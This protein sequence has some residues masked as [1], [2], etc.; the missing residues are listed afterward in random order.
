[1]VLALR[2]CS[3]YDD[4]Q[5]CNNNY[6]SYVDGLC[7]FD[8]DKGKN[9]LVGTSDDVPR[10]GTFQDLLRQQPEL[11]NS[12][13]TSP[14]ECPSR[15]TLDLNVTYSST[16]A[17]GEEKVFKIYVD[18][19]DSDIL[20]QIQT[21]PNWNLDFKSLNVWEG[22]MNMYW[23]ADHGLTDDSW[24][25][26]SPVSSPKPNDLTWADFTSS[27]YKPVIAAGTLNTTELLRRWQKYSGLDASPS[28][29]GV[30]SLGVSS[31]I[32][33]AQDPR[34]FAGYYVF[35]LTNNNPSEIEFSV[36]VSA[37][38]HTNARPPPSG[39]KFDLATLG[40]IMIGVILAVTV[41]VFVIRKIRRMMEERDMARLA[42]ELRMLDEEEEEEERNR[43]MNGGVRTRRN[44]EGVEKKPMYKIV[45]GVQA[46]VTEQGL[47]HRSRT[48][49]YQGEPATTFSKEPVA[50]VSEDK[51]RSRVRS[52]YIRDLGTLANN[53][54]DRQDRLSKTMSV[55]EQ[56]IISSDLVMP[57][58]A[59]SPDI[60]SFSPSRRDS[61]KLDR[62]HSQ[63][64]R[65]QSDTEQDGDLRLSSGSNF[66]T[67][68]NLHRGW[69]LRSLGRSA[70]LKRIR[71]TKVRAEEREG[72]TQIEGSDQESE[73]PRPLDSDH[74]D[75]LDLATLPP[76]SQIRLQQ[77]PPV[78]LKRRNPIRIQPISIEPVPF[79]GALVPQTVRHLKKYH[80]NLAK[81]AR[82][83][84][85]R[86][87]ALEQQYQSSSPT[88]VNSTQSL[89][90][91][92]G[93]SRTFSKRSFT[94]GRS[95]SRRAARLSPSQG[96][97][98]QVQRT[99][100]LMTSRTFGGRSKAGTPTRQNSGEQRARDQT[101]EWLQDEATGIELA[102]MDKRGEHGQ[103]KIFEPSEE[104][105]NMPRKPMRM[106]GR[107][108]YDPGPLLAV[109]VL[110][111]FPGD[112]EARK[113]MQGGEMDG[114][115]G[116][117]P[118]GT[119]E[120]HHQD[121]LY[122]SNNHGYNNNDND[123]EDKDVSEQ[124]LPPMAIGTVFAP[125]PVRWWAYKAQ[126]LEDR[127]HFE[128]KLQKLEKQKKT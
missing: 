113:V 96:S 18:A 26:S 47:R 43:R 31:L 50:T 71:E 42:L 65:K 49:R 59:S 52:D 41:L 64:E 33:S 6:C 120:Q 109:N 124:R 56:D 108:E 72:L 14:N 57:Q 91:G 116:T 7:L 106:R 77:Q 46:L 45:V 76:S 54:R 61:K 84:Q 63:Q 53:I 103:G 13:L 90:A 78:Q 100:S 36:T 9:A 83:R 3:Q 22:F 111:V 58:T 34:R 118:F 48:I 60:G 21:V 107:R 80:R 92:P 97:L 81:N 38:N 126:H 51:R 86:Q 102:T 101:Q 123:D 98:R 10:D 75:M 1:M 79:H 128:R 66:S 110:I 20:F 104:M 40:F 70:S 74:E 30:R 99:A 28:S 23:R 5:N 93:P 121:T 85:Q 87:Q 15:I 27:E 35:A 37:L 44:E 117:Q 119:G 8:T 11:K 89:S 127:R 39:A 68:L 19:T 125:D 94:V 4:C 32:F 24:D 73:V 114:G 12:V 115:E 67:S 95:A 25:G 62:R 105:V 82:R 2:W 122:N 17:A 16:I 29:S 112:A 69:S 55:S 88:S